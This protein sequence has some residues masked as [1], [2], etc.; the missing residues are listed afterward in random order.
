MGCIS[1][2]YEERAKSVFLEANYSPKCNTFYIEKDGIEIGSN[3]SCNS[4]QCVLK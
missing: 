4:N 1:F 3:I 2:L